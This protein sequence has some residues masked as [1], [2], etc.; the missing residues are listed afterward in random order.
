V[1]RMGTRGIPGLL[2]IADNL[3]RQ[4]ARTDLIQVEAVD[5]TNPPQPP[6]MTPPPPTPAPGSP[7]QTIQQLQNLQQSVNDLSTKIDTQQKPQTPQAPQANQQQVNVLQQMSNALQ[8]QVSQMQNTK[9]S[10]RS[11]WQSLWLDPQ[12]NVY[13]AEG[14]HESWLEW[15]GKRMG[16]KPAKGEPYPGIAE[17]IKAG[18]I[19]LMVLENEVGIQSP[20][21][22]DT[23]LHQVQLTLSSRGIKR[24]YFSWEPSGGHIFTGLF[25]DF[26]TANHVYELRR[27]LNEPTTAL[28]SV[29]RRTPM[30]K[31]STLRIAP[32]WL[33]SL[34]VE[35]RVLAQALNRE[36]AQEPIRLEFTD[37]Y[38]ALGIPYPDPATVCPGQCEGTGMVPVKIRNKER[39]LHGPVETDPRLIALWKVAEKE[40]P[41]D[42]GWHFVQC[43]DCRG[44]GKVSHNRR[45]FEVRGVRIRPACG[46][47]WLDAHAHEVPA[48]AQSSAQEAGQAPHPAWP[49]IGK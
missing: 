47:F 38:Q 44:S 4:I 40:S 36:L 20:R 16:I 2:M 32:L 35:A 7:D 1:A 22:D 33:P 42:D 15:K 30:W 10:A 28:A 25:D 17:A 48:L 41:S 5:A 18:W 14:T 19:R 3:L 26:A 46:G 11:S 12:G 29:I 21:Q 23:T 27:G 37:R 49:A 24:Q 6:S 45:V 43:P 34:Q 39:G 9:A 31:G 8:Q 13:D